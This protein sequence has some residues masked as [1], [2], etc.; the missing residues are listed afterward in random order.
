MGMVK[1]DDGWRLPD[2]LWAQREQLLPPRK[3]LPLLPGDS[4]AVLDIR[5]I[6]N[7]HRDRTRQ[8]KAGACIIVTRYTVL[9]ND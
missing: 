9:L 5:D 8:R 7:A 2:R 1:Q 4:P 6:H 3:L